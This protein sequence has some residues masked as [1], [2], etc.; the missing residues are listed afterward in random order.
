[1]V[2]LPNIGDDVLIVPIGNEIYMIP[3]GNFP[4]VGEDIGI[5]ELPDGTMVTTG[6]S[7]P[8]EGNGAIIYPL[9]LSENTDGFKEVMAITGGECP[10]I[11]TKISDEYSRFAPVGTV[12]N[13]GI[14]TVDWKCGKVWIVS[15]PTADISTD[16]IWV[17]DMIRVIGPKGTIE[18]HNIVG[19]VIGPIPCFEITSILDYGINQVQIQI[20]TDAPT[21]IGCS[22]LWFVRR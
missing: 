12:D 6:K 5:F 1:M 20:I 10:I 22:S 16:K 13:L 11:S 19:G 14:F 17:D 4:Q 8:T 3:K 9:T 21:H 15:S 2:N 18:K 7:V